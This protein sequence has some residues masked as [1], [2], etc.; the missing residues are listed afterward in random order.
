MWLRLVAHTRC[1][2]IYEPYGTLADWDR[3]IEEVH[4]HG[5]KL[6]MDLVVNHCSSE[7]A[8]FKDAIS[9]K[10]SKH[11]D[12]FIWR[13]GTKDE[14]GKP[15]PPNNWRSV[16]GHGPAWTYDEASDEWYLRLFVS[17]QPDL[18]WENPAVREAVYDLMKFWL[19]KGIDGFRMDVIN[20]ISKVPG[21]P[22]APIVDKDSQYQPGFI[23]CANGPRVHE[24]LKEMNSKVLSKYD[25]LT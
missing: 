21:L 25:I 2:D 15:L 9:S 5:M 1:R 11:R 10:D 6:V 19:D 13:K 14:Q 20:L 22:D 7:H 12:W 17:Q 18:N 8:W 16:F 4:Q 23:Y 3:L 24:F